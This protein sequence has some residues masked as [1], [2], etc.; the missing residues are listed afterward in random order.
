MAQRRTT[1][2]STAIAAANSTC[3]QF[4]GGKTFA[5]MTGDISGFS[6]N[7]QN[8]QHNRHATV[9]RSPAPPKPQRAP[10]PSTSTSP[11]LANAEPSAATTASSAVLLSPTPSDDRQRAESANGVQP[12]AS[13]DEIPPNAATLPETLPW[14]DPEAD[15]SS[16]PP[17]ERQE[18]E[19]AST[20]D[21][22]P[23][24]NPF[25]A[26]TATPYHPTPNGDGPQAEAPSGGEWTAMPR[27][28]IPS[29]ALST[30]GSTP[31]TRV[32]PRPPGNPPKRLGESG[33]T[34]PQKRLRSGPIR[35]HR[36]EHSTPTATS[37]TVSW[38]SLA[39][40]SASSVQ[41]VS[42]SGKL[43]ARSFCFVHN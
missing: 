4:L 6:R 9:S 27:Y 11:T 1:G 36:S 5:W 18:A 30:P 22:L 34:N 21:M 15:Q 19:L 28:S 20:A 41:T 31:P 42:A 25:I 3:N 13:V 32:P 38:P 17:G 24:T 35:V 26:D 2:S 23:A 10:S 37:S 40:T 33:I 14:A 29:F 8:N 7:Q 39:F 16:T 43:T 12:T